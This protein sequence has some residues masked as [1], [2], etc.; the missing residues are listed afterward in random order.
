MRRV[1][2][3]LRG[4][5]PPSLRRHLLA[6]AASCSPPPLGC[7]LGPKGTGTPTATFGI[8]S[9]LNRLRPTAPVGGKRGTA[10][11]ITT[12]INH[13]NNGGPVV[14]MDGRLL[15][16][17]RDITS[18]EDLQDTVGCAGQESGASLDDQSNVLRMKRVDI[19]QGMYGV[20]N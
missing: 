19:L 9:A 7:P 18:M 16:G 3:A 8:V 2:V 10:M 15:A 5:I 13:G 6:R 4:G 20:Q 12:R 14:T 17:D 11:Q 1:K